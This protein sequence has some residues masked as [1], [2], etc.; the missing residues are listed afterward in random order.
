MNAMTG[1]QRDAGDVL[2]GAVAG[3]IGGLVAAFV[4]SEFQS[5]WNKFAGQEKQRDS[6]KQ[7]PAT[8]KAA[9]MIVENAAD[10][11]L[12]DDEKKYAGPLMHYAMGGTSGAI[13][14]AFSELMPVARLGAGLP[15]GAAVWL[16]ADDLI[17]PALGLSKPVTDYPLSKNV[18]ALASHLVFG[19]STEA[20]RGAVRNIL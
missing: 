3:L 2:R 13:Y 1:E 16:L 9:Q 17:V 6:E 4:M 18:Y 15:F 8:V 7:E 5:V 20:V 12:T 14:G 19:V 11:E 10:H